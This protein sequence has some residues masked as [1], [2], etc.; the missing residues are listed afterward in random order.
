MNFSHIS[1]GAKLDTQNYLWMYQG[2]VHETPF[3]LEEVTLEEI[4][5]IIKAIDIN[6]SSAIEYLSAMALRDL[7]LAVPGRFLKIINHSIS[8]Q[9]FPTAWKNAAVTPLK[10]EPKANTVNQLRPISLLPVPGKIL[11]RLVY[12]QTIKHLDYY[13]ILTESQ[14]GFRKKE[15]NSSHNSRTNRLYQPRDRGNM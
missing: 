8:Q 10:K 12:N 9:K 11:E 2:E 6:K 3:S 13:N 1:V 4:L 5:P 15:V 7:L 14:F